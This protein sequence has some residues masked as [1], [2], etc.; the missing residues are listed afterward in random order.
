[1]RTGLLAN[2]ITAPS[3]VG[4]VTQPSAFPRLSPCLANGVTLASLA[5]RVTLRIRL[6]EN[7]QKHVRNIAGSRCRWG[8][9]VTPPGRGEV[10]PFRKESGQGAWR[11]GEAIRT[12]SGQGKKLGAQFLRARPPSD[13]P[14]V[15]SRGPFA[16]CSQSLENKV[17]T[18]GKRKGLAGLVES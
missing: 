9:A 18:D 2:M 17:P 3:H 8:A 7:K 14:A 6:H 12:C 16:H 4:C 10:L 11:S 13:C 15:L 1:M 5:S